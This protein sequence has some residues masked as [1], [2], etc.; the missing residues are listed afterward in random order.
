MHS[1]V[2]CDSQAKDHAIGGEE[3]G[4]ISPAIESGEKGSIS[5]S[6]VAER[7]N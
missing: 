3:E 1:F 4:R 2:L 5:A 7:I 6:V